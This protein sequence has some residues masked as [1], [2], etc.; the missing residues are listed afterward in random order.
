MKKATHTWGTVGWRL[1][2]ETNHFILSGDSGPHG[3]TNHSASFLNQNRAGL[4]LWASVHRT[5]VFTLRMSQG[6][7]KVMRNAKNNLCLE[8]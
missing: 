1:P 8:F 4:N 7:S 2:R 5:N 6:Q 3:D